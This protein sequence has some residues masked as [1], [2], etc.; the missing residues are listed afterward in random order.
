MQHR[1]IFRTFFIILFATAAIP[2]IVY[3]LATTAVYFNFIEE[4]LPSNTKVM[5][6]RAIVIEMA[7]MVGLAAI[8][9]LVA[10]YTALSRLIRP[11]KRLLE[12]TR[13]V[14]EGKTPKMLT[15]A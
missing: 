8:I 9:V 1:S 6:E 15:A 13:E 4:F 11:L 10:Y 3:S 7:L 12:F 14:G 5:V 2:T